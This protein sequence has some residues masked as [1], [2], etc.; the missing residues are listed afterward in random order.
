MNS[1]LFE[2][3]KT[4]KQ[5]HNGLIPPGVTREVIPKDCQIEKAIVKGDEQPFLQVVTAM[6]G[7]VFTNSILVH[8]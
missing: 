3:F 2:A 5:A 7:I 1:K 6:F 4:G 8:G